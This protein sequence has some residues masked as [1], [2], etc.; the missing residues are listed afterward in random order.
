ME[1]NINGKTIKGVEIGVK[2]G[3]AIVK[4]ALGQKVVEI[5]IFSKFSF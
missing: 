3:K 4:T 5:F 2:D 1:I